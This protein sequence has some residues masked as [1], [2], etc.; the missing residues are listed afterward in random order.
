MICPN[1][2]LHNYGLQGEVP[3]TLMSGKADDIIHLFEF[4]WFQ[5]VVFYQPTE[6][7]PDKHATIGRYLAPASDVGTTMTHK[8]LFLNMVAVFVEAPCKPG[9]PRKR[10]IYP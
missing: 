2:V 4:E 3:E 9:S 5:W 8:I 10:P 7:Y 1:T 6:T